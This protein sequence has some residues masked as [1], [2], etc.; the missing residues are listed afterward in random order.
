[1]LENIL[2]LN[3]F[4]LLLVF[5]RVG[6]ALMMM[7]GFSAVYVTANIR[8]VLAVVISA[9]CLPAVADVLPAQPTSST[10]LV[11]LLFMEVSIGLYLGIMAQF[12]LVSVGLAGSVIGFST[13]LM[14]AQAFDPMISQQSAIVSGLLSQLVMVLIF[15]MGL[16]HVMI[17]AIFGSYAVFPPGALPD[18]GDA[19]R[20]LV[21]IMGDGFR[22]GF[23][24][25]AP[26]AVYGIIF[27]ATLGV[28]ARLMPQLNVMFIA[29]PA[30][31]IFG[32][33][34]LMTSGPFILMSFLRAFEQGL[35]PLVP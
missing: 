9:V 27:N 33:G 17:E 10:T 18:T 14:M 23:Q 3:V 1:M 28:I 15:V 35:R 8:L 12:L 19:V 32:L 22:L 7:P 30:Q 5:T 11:M 16:H 34:L 20:L 25:A 21:Q 31:I 24:I 6:A 2:A 29:M 13:G 26:F 4:H